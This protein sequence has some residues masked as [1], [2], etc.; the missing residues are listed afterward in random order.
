MAAGQPVQKPGEYPY[1]AGLNVLS[2]IAIAGG[3]TYRATSEV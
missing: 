2:A 3:A 1:R